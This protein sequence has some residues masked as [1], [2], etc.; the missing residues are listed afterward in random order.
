MAQVIFILR[1]HNLFLLY[2]IFLSYDVMFHCV[3][4]SCKINDNAPVLALDMQISKIKLCNGAY[5][6][7]AFTY[8][9]IFI[10]LLHK[11]VLSLEYCINLV[12]NYK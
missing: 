4:K 12:E 7:T 10:F 6:N 1:R 8:C 9:K 5:S 2:K 3:I 11:K